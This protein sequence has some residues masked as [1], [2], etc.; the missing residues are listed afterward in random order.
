M[1]LTNVYNHFCQV[2]FIWFVKTMS[3]GCQIQNIDANQIIVPINGIAITGSSTGDVLVIKDGIINNLSTTGDNKILTSDS[4]SYLGVTWKNQVAGVSVFSA[5]ID[6]VT[7]NDLTTTL[8]NW[9]VTSPEYSNAAFNASTGILTIPENG[10]YTFTV[11]INYTITAGV[12]SQLG[13][14]VNPGFVLRKTTPSVVDLSSSPIPIFNVNTLV[15]TLR[16][17]LAAAQI[18]LTGDFNLDLGDTVE[19][20]Y[21]ADG[22]TTSLS[23]GEFYL[24]GV[25]YS[26]SRIG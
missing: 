26:V 19:V 18:I 7:I 23:L 22:F 8:T 13:A 17:T 14:D 25:T 21:N 5:R 16:V 1:C 6:T 12:T 20:V 10:K 3:S 15:L 11:N 2:H 9:T 24:P 4:T